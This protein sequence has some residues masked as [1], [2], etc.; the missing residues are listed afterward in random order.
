MRRCPGN[1]KFE[2]A[3]DEKG[4]NYEEKMSPFSLL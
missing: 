3:C 4:W 2:E 1:E